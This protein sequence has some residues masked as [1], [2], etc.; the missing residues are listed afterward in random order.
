VL[1]SARYLADAFLLPLLLVVCVIAGFDVRQRLPSIHTAICISSTICAAVG[2]AEI[3]T[4]QDLLPVQN[5]V[6]FYAGGIARPNGPFAAN[7]QFAL[8]GAVSFFFLVFLRA[9]LGPNVTLGRRMLHFVGI[10]A[11]LGTALMPMFRSVAITLLIALVIDSFW[12]QKPNRRAWRVVLIVISVV[13]I[14]GA[15]L[16]LPSM[17]LEDRSGSGNVYGRIAQ[18]KQSFHVFAD[19]PAFGVGFLNFQNAVAGNSIYVESYAGVASLDSPHN[20]LTQVLAETGLLGLVTYVLAHIF[21]FR[22]AWQ[23]RRSSSS[24][25]LVWRSCIYLFL[26]YWITGLTESSGYS[27]LNVIYFSMIALIYKYALTAPDLNVNEHR[28]FQT[29]ERVFTAPARVF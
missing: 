6:M 18:L 25:P 28:E 1:N 8:V 10:T 26:C 14:F 2:A 7:D 22:T 4:G 12:K 20:N 29:S 27:P 24:G 13:V 11:A 15:P 3:A 16:F 9:A 21:L 19:H 17:L 5:S 23:L